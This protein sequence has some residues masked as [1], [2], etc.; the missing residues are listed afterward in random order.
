[1]KY[2]KPKLFIYEKSRIIIF[3]R[4]TYYGTGGQS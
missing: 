1:M 4:P 2:E 3:Y